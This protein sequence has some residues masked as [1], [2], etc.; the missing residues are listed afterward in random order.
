MGKKRA[1]SIRRLA[2]RLLKNNPDI[3]TENFEENKRLV[4]EVVTFPSKHIR[5]QVAG[6]IQRLKKRESTPLLT[7]M[8]A[9]SVRPSFPRRRRGGSWR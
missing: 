8:P 2:E 1:I 6:Y 7:Q 4:G 5:N 3:F 9:P